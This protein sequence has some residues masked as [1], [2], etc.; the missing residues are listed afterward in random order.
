MKHTLKSILIYNLD[1]DRIEIE[2]RKKLLVRVLDKTLCSSSLLETE[3]ALSNS[4]RLYFGGRFNHR[5]EAIIESSKTDQE[6]SSS[7]NKLNV[8]T[9][10]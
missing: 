6:L 4:L 7:S 1:R 10:P 2:L 8:V 9:I 5:L 3:Q